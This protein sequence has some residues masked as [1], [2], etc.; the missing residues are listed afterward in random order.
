MRRKA[1]LLGFVL[2]LV[3]LSGCITD[4]ESVSVSG[5]VRPSTIAMGLDGLVYVADVTVANT[6]NRPVGFQKY[7]AGFYVGKEEMQLYS[8]DKFREI[9][10]GETLTFSVQSKSFFTMKREAEK[11]GEKIK[12]SFRLIKDGKTLGGK[13]YTADVPDMSQVITTESQVLP[14]SFAVSS[15][16]S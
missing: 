4:G 11:S 3:L 9:Y 13:T 1:C 5:Q 15:A 7:E 6:G 14:L 10:P 8:N 2:S 12:L 16:G